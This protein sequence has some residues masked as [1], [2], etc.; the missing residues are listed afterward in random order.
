MCL[1]QKKGQ[2]I[3]DYVHE[4]EKLSERVPTDMNDMLAMAFI[5]GLHDQESRRRISYDLR[6]TPEFTFS[7]AVH[8][9]KSWYQEIEVPDPF[10]R[11][12]VGFR[13][14]SKVQTPIYATPAAGI[15]A[16]REETTS[17]SK[18]EDLQPVNP[19]QNA[20]NQMMVN[21]MGNMKDFY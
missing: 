17:S 11:F 10:N 8:M 2:S 14:S 13:D 4:T 15:V 18:D 9:V 3:V 20:F 7:K 16:T 19:L 5:R 12:G 1:Q 6:D 21:F